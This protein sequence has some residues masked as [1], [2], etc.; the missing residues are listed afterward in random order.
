M[1]LI[2]YIDFFRQFAVA[3]LDHV[4]DSESDS[5]T[6]KSSQTFAIYNVDDLNADMR[7]TIADNKPCLFLS[8]YDVR[9]YENEFKSEFKAEH[10]GSLLMV[11]YAASK[12]ISDRMLA[13]HNCETKLYTLINQLLNDSQTSACNWFHNFNFNSVTIT[14]EEN[15]FNGMYGWYMKF[16]Y[17]VKL[18]NLQIIPTS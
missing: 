4:I 8:M 3:N 14:A 15:L 2:S 18:P 17:S 6:D 5:P 11:Q 12:S 10:T 13:F 16:S 9:G 1:H 7:S